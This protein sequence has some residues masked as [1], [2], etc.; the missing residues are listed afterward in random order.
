MWCQEASGVGCN[1]L[2]ENTKRNVAILIKRYIALLIKRER[3][4]ALLIKTERYVVLV[5][6]TKRYVATQ[7][8]ANT[9]EE[10]AKVR[11]EFLQISEDPSFRPSLRWFSKC[12]KRW[13][14]PK[15][16]KS[17]K[18]LS[19]EGRCQERVWRRQS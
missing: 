7:I 13:E 12:N 6:K 16:T 9:A 8:K 4:V 15:K 2:R 14:N 18:T 1:V 17:Q 10:Q 19:L 11:S 3:Y 5:I